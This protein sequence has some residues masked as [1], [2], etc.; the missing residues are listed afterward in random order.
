MTVN[1]FR[2]WLMQE[3]NQYFWKETA[4]PSEQMDGLLMDKN[5]LK[6]IA[7]SRSNQYLY[8]FIENRIVNGYADLIDYQLGTLMQHFH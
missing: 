6:S 7:S 2:T 4:L 3:Q 5:I 1:Y 8:G